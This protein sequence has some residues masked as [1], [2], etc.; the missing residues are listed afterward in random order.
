MRA[1]ALARWR[2]RV[3]R[4]R[5]VGGAGGG[6]GGC[7]GEAEEGALRGGEGDVGQG[8]FGPQQGGERDEDVDD[9]EYA[10]EVVGVCWVWVEACYGVREECEPGGRRVSSRSQ[11]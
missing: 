4:R 5:H 8:V 7:G 2:A 3:P 11:R 10:D 9:E 6:R 1:G